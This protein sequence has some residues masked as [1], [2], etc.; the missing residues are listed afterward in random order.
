MKKTK[1]RWWTLLILTGL[2]QVT[3]RRDDDDLIPAGNCYLAANVDGQDYRWDLNNCSLNGQTLRVGNIAGDEAE[4]TLAPVN[5]TGTFESLDPNVQLTLVLTLGPAQQIIPGDV[6]IQL[7]TFSATEARG[8]FE[9]IFT[10]V[11]GSNYQVA[12]GEFRAI[13]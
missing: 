4:L 12:N 5:G 8:T 10:D 7:T 13:F 3:C 1:L 9:G 11:G 6:Q 2:L